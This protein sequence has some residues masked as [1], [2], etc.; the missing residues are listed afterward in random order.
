MTNGR[1]RIDRG[2]RRRRVAASLAGV[3]LTLWPVTALAQSEAESR[4]AA[5]ALGTEGIALAMQGD[6][7]AAI[8]KL[9]RAED[10]Y[11]APTILERLGECQIEVGQLVA[12]TENL[13]R[14]VR[15]PLG[16]NPPA[17]YV[18]A[19]E[20]ARQA[21]ERALP[22]IAKLTVNVNAPP[23]AAVEVALNEKP[24]PAA[25]VGVERP[26][27]P[28]EYVVTVRGEG[29]TSTSQTVKLADGAVESVTLAVELLPTATPPPAA[30]PPVEPAPLAPA[31]DDAGARE[32]NPLRTAGYVLLGVG[33][34]GVVVG[35]IFGVKALGQRSDLDETCPD[36][37][38]P[39]SAED[40]LDALRSTAT[41]STVGI[42]V[43][44]GAA[45]V[46]TVLVFTSSRDRE[47]PVT[48]AGQA[49][50]RRVEVRGAVG[51]SG[52]VL[53]GRF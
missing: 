32:G 7:P 37:I 46:G 53:S 38:C 15:E 44:L 48:P 27:D 33:G 1:H 28:G 24:L 18:E 14:V 36:R 45:A 13:Q 20:R 52:L 50:A 26:I 49:S 21:L 19:Q 10:L 29:V 42:G 4:A 3:L 16:P 11:H 5:R 9:Q 40:D 35:S 39:R 23:G 2:S 6:C 12:G 22:R 51:P 8:D 34:V 31:P 47:R 41:V 43:G 25:M 17:P 30:P